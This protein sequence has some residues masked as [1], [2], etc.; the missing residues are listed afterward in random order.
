MPSRASPVRILD[1]S[2]AIR[3]AIGEL[4]SSGAKRRV[5]LTAFV[6]E[7]AGAFIH[8]PKAIE[9]ICWPRAGGTNPVEL[10][11]LKAAG[12]KIRFADRLHMKLYWAAG[13][14]VIITAANLTT[15]AL[16]A[17]D[18][19][20]FGVL[21]PSDS[22]AID[23]VIRSVKPRLFNSSEMHQLE[24]EHRRL[25]ARRYDYQRKREKLSYRRW[26]TLMPRSEWKLGWW[27]TVG[28]P[29]TSAKKRAKAEF[30]STKP[31]NFVS[32]RAKDY[33]PDDWVLTFQL[34][35]RG[36]SSPEWLYVDFVVKVTRNDK[37]YFKHY[38]FQAVQV[39]AP[40][41]YPNPPFAITKDFRNAL[42][43]AAL[44]FGAKRLKRFNSKPP[45][46]FLAMIARRTK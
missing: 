5:A 2:S 13:R 40:R 37:A 46:A 17:G 15:N 29:S 32:C 41:T 45:A 28:T 34:T 36:A 8:N 9:I 31:H 25:K 35:D 16:G 6:G 3:R 12:A 27:D 42:R 11:K 44:R 39:S 14:G 43:R 19:K 1:S 10:K 7:G 26:Y 33:A 38:P 21:L 23:D 30:N 20:E 18:L 24:R 4:M 22:V